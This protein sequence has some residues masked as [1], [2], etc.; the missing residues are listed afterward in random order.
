[1]RAAFQRV[2]QV[3]AV[4]WR[5][6]LAVAAILRELFPD[7]KTRWQAAGCLSVPVFFLLA[8]IAYW[9]LCSWFMVPVSVFTVR[10]G[11]Q[12]LAALRQQYPSATSARVTSSRGQGRLSGQMW[13]VVGVAWDDPMSRTT[14]NKVYTCNGTPDRLEV[15]R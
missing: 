6:P 15:E 7:R 8:G 10:C 14:E 9:A 11:G 5:F 12:A 4:T 3:V 1:M 2:F 13:A